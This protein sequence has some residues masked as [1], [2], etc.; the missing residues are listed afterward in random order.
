MCPPGFTG[1]RCQDGE[2][3]AH[4]AECRGGGSEC[5]APGSQQVCCSCLCLGSVSARLVRP[6]LPAEL[7]LWERGPLPSC[8]GD[9]Q[10][11]ARLDG[12]R[13]PER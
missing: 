7:Q 6:C 5:R 10:L 8:D 9:L 3:R 2:C 4:G 13:L 12:P 11:R 1:S